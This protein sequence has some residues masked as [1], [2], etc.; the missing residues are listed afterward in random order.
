[1]FLSILPTCT[2]SPT[3]LKF[4]PFL[5][6]KKWKSN[7][8]LDLRLRSIK[9]TSENINIKF[10]FRLIGNK[11]KYEFLPCGITWTQIDDFHNDD[12]GEAL[13]IDKS[14]I[15]ESK[16]KLNEDNNIRTS[17]LGNQ[18]NDKVYVKE[19]KFGGE[20]KK[21]KAEQEGVVEGKNDTGVEPYLKKNVEYKD[22]KDNPVR[23]I[24]R[25]KDQQ[26][27]YSS[28]SRLCPHILPII[29]D[30]L[31]F[32]PKINVNGKKIVKKPSLQNEKYVK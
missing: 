25:F 28:K 31:P 18:E 8:H 1:M 22:V 13:V 30:H 23:K 15:K 16:A 7:L 27:Q 14:E 32:A 6:M 21:N 5:P 9:I 17:D 26:N 2:R 12:T 19:N 24:S 11:R 20:N 29:G 4:L 3:C 10:I